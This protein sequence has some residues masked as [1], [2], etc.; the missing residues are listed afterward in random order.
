MA[1]LL[2]DN[3]QKKKDLYRKMLAEEATAESTRKYSFPKFKE[4]LSGDEVLLDKVSDIAVKKGWSSTKDD[5]YGTYFPELFTP[6]APPTPKPQAAPKQEFMEVPALEEQEAYV[7]EPQPLVGSPEYDKQLQKQY[8]GMAP[9][10]GATFGGVPAAFETKE[11][12]KQ[13]QLSPA[14]KAQQLAFEDVPIAEEQRRAQKQFAKATKQQ[15]QAALRGGTG[16]ELK[17]TRQAEAE[18][19]GDRV[20][21]NIE[22]FWEGAKN[23]GIQLFNGL[24]TVMNAAALNETPMDDYERE[25]YQQKEFGKM[26]EESKKAEDDFQDELYRLNVSNDVLKSVEEGNYG[27]IPEAALQTIGNVAVSAISSLLTAGG[28]MYYQTLPQQYKEGVEAIAK[29]KGITPEDVIRSGDDAKITAQTVGGIVAALE[30]AGAGRLSKSIMNKG[31]YKAVRDFLIRNG[32]GKAVGRAGGLAYSGLGEFGTEYT[33]QGA[34]Q[35]GR[36]AAASEDASKFYKKFPKE[37]FSKEA[38]RERL[39]AG[40][41]G[42]VGGAG[43]VGIGRGLKKAIS[44]GIS[45][46]KF[47]EDVANNELIQNAAKGYEDNIARAEEQGRKPD[48]FNQKQLN[49]ITS[50]PEAWVKSEIKYLK[51]TIESNKKANLDSKVEENSLAKANALL[52]QIIREKKAIEQADIASAEQPIAPQEEVEAVSAE[53]LQGPGYRT[54]YAKTREEIPVEYRNNIAEIERPTTRLGRFGPMEKVFAYRVPTETIDI[55]PQAPTEVTPEPAVTETAPVAEEIPFEEVTPVTEEVTVAPL[56]EEELAQIEETELTPEEEAALLAQEETAP[57]PAEEDGLQPGER[58]IGGAIVKTGYAPTLAVRPAQQTVEQQPAAP[59][60]PAPTG[61]PVPFTPSVSFGDIKLSP[62][63]HIG[64]T[65]AVEHNGEQKDYTITKV[66]TDYVL[67]TDEN[68]DRISIP[69]YEWSRNVNEPSVPAEPVAPE[70]APQAE[71]IVSAAPVEEAAPEAPAAPAPKG[72]K[73]KGAP[74]TPAPAA[75]ETKEG[76]KAEAKEEKVTPKLKD[77]KIKPPSDNVS[78]VAQSSGLT[79]GKKKYYK[80]H[81]RT[82]RRC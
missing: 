70:V 75:P 13:E 41:G 62:Q 24:K 15:Q 51:Q 74:V 8:G 80:A 60:P 59:P 61:I 65:I 73:K 71:E 42:F 30:R 54:A 31:G 69:L 27:K 43:I 14:F 12:K 49:K 3:E 25:Y 4:R 66:G 52:A 34:Q 50:D 63:K 1:E 58:R 79:A 10:L 37:F 53:E 33:Q 72:K 18:G 19:T 81:I 46:D 68:G 9:T 36:I 29:E 76:K 57:A 44:G 7:P 35:L 56:T 26:Y 6:Q 77:Y 67:V 40:I 47:S 39:G 82:K 32:F 45:L 2:D 20:A 21:A 5:F 78:E 23:S 38:V 55:T 16:A 22:A 64:E 28:S 11:Q 17:K 48:S